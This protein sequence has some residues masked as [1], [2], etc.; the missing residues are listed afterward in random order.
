[1][2]IDDLQ[3]YRNNGDGIL[4][5][6]VGRKIAIIVSTLHFSPIGLAQSVDINLVNR[7]SVRS[8]S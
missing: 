8:E 7:P 6:S 2:C 5:L 4:Q 1:M 3:K